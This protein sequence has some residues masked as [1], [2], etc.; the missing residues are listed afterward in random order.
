MFSPY[1]YIY[2]Y[3]YVC[4]CLCRLQINIMN[5]CHFWKH[6]LPVQC[7]YM[8][9]QHVLILRFGFSAARCKSRSLQDAIRAP[10]L[11]RFSAA[12]TCHMQSCSY[13]SLNRLGLTESIP[14]LY[15]HKTTECLMCR[16]LGYL[17]SMCRALQT[18]TRSPIRPC[19]GWL[20][21]KSSP[22]V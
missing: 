16:Y 5:L 3:T 8:F 21:E 20:V 7:L 2:I 13:V 15:E 19:T 17:L 6:I 1:A 12:K 11:P 10:S 4:V 22:G 9:V 18:G 14:K